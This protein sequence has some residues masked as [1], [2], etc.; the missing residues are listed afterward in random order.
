MRCGAGFL[1]ISRDMK[2]LIAAFLPFLG[3]ACIVHDQVPIKTQVVTYPLGAVVEFNGRVVGR[4]PAAV[5]LPQDTNGRLTERAV[6]R[7]VPN[8]SQATLLAQ[9]RILD[10]DSLPE[11]VPDQI[12][13]DLTL[14]VTSGNSGAA[15]ASNLQNATNHFESGST[16]SRE[17]RPGRT[18]DRGKPTQPVGVNRWNPGIY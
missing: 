4:S 7:A 13:I 17:A 2:F 12:M 11:R 10:P 3:A 15:I 6:L 9:T 5:I 1:H 8:T 14:P 16:K 18:L